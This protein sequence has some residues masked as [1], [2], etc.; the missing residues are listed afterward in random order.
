MADP[1][2]LPVIAAHDN[3]FNW[4][5]SV[6][7]VA[8]ALTNKTLT[9]TLKYIG[10]GSPLTLTLASGITV[11]DTAAGKFKLVL[12]EAQ[13]LNMELDKPVNCYLTIWNADNSAWA[14]GKFSL[15]KT[16]G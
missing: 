8:Q 9:A 16:L 3:T 13:V 7:G 14:H 1:I 15:I 2:S 10:A 11:T 5:A 4:Q 12:T 6:D